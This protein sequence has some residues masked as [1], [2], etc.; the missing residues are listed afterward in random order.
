MRNRQHG[1]E[2]ANGIVGGRIKGRRKSRVTKLG[3]CGQLIVNRGEGISKLLVIL[4]KVSVQKVADM[5]VICAP[6]QQI[7]TVQR[8]RP[9][10]LKEVA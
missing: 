4:S 7:E 8:T 5:G 3:G 1:Y 10:L 2:A 9:H 6:A